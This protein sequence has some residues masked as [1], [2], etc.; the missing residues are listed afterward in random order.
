MRAVGSCGRSHFTRFADILLCDLHNAFSA[1]ALHVKK[2]A[3][4][5]AGNCITVLSLSKTDKSCTC[6]T[7]SGKEKCQRIYWRESLIAPATIITETLSTAHLRGTATEA[8]SID[9]FCP[10]SGALTQPA[11]PK[12]SRAES[13]ASA[14]LFTAQQSFLALVNA[15]RARAIR[16]K[17]PLAGKKEVSTRPA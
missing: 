17:T 15:G 6:T 1:S 10:N 5:P 11:P 16:R 9:S 3:S 8:C 14:L 4:A 13:E 2:L 12:T 7:V